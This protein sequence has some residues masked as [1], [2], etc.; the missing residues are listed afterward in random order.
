MSSTDTIT[1]VSLGNLEVL[2]VADGSRQGPTP[3]GIVR[4]ASD[5]EIAQALEEGGYT[6][7]TMPFYFNPV[8]VKGPFGLVLIDTGNGKAAFKQSNGAVGQLQQNL[9]SYGIDSREINNVL[10]THFHGDHIN[11]LLDDEGRPQFSQ[12]AIH[13]PQKE[14][15]YWMDD[16]AMEAT[17]DELKPH[18][19]NCRRVFKTLKNVNR[20]DD[21]AEVL[22]GISAHPTPGHTPGHTSFLVT[23]DNSSKLFVQ[24]DVTNLPAL[25][26]RRPHWRARFDIDPELAESTRKRVYEWLATEGLLVTG[27]HYPRPSL[28]TIKRRSPGFECVYDT[29]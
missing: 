27:Y 23:G 8:L 17:S 10:I 18:F 4:N 24:G 22:P 1:R 12:A 25:F 7:G 14:W 3:K 20:F 21:S 26:V 16:K 6:P 2:I 11:G 9:S 13:V 28:A 15:D 5:Q 19:E 29:E